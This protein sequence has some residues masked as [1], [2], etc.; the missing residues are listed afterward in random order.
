MVTV[1][2]HVTGGGRET[3][4]TVTTY[5][6]LSASLQLSDIDRTDM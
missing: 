6:S 4:I 1:N 5:Q 3:N 2:I